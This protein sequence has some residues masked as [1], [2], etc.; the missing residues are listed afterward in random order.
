M[1]IRR[2]TSPAHFRSVLEGCRADGD[3]LICWVGSPFCLRSAGVLPAFRSAARD[4]L[5]SARATQCIQCIECD[6][7]LVP[8]L[9]K[10]LSIDSLPQC[11][12]L[13]GARRVGMMVRERLTLVT[14]ASIR[15][16]FREVRAA[17]YE[18]SSSAPGSVRSVT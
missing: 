11:V 16:W 9:S 3:D 6:I 17:V 4:L 8:F 1:R 12:F 13:R 14:P 18:S 5:R 15:A 7:A 10:M 2:I